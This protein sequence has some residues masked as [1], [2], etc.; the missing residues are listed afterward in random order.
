MFKMIDF[1][2]LLLSAS[3]PFL[4]FIRFL[5]Y[6][7]LP[8]SR[9]HRQEGCRRCWLFSLPL[10]IARCL[11]GCFVRLQRETGPNTRSMYVNG[12]VGENTRF[13]VY[14]ISR[15]QEALVSQT[16]LIDLMSR[17]RG[18]PC[19]A[20]GTFFLAPFGLSWGVRSWTFLMT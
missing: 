18:F 20:C 8:T 16:P 2:F 17:R 4:P 12:G 7:V 19:L 5:F 6:F 9:S 10:C 3:F 14:S 15:S 13:S 11:A 1:L